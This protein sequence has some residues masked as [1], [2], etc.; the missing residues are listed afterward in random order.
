MFNKN[1]KTILVTGCA[2]F[3]GSNFLPYFLEKFIGNETL[4]SENKKLMLK[5]Q[6]EIK[7]K[8]DI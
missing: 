1:N 4:V 6:F 5:H 2:R 7:E 8:K 3:I